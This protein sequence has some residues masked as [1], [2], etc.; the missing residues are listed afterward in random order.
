MGAMKQLLDTKTD[1]NTRGRDGWIALY[2]VV[3][4]GS[5]EAAAGGKDGGQRVG[6][7]W[8]D[9]GICRRVEGRW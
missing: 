4:N 1:V 9:C 5:D 7:G 6:L 3:L 8:M 2:V